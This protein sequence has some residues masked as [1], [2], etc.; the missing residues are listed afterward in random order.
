MKMTNTAEIKFT[1][2]SWKRFIASL[3]LLG[4]GILDLIIFQP[5]SGRHV[6]TGSIMT[7]QGPSYFVSAGL[8]PLLVGI[9]LILYVIFS[10]FKGK[11]FQKED[12]ITFEEKRYFLR[13]ETLFK[14]SDILL[15]RLTNNEIGIKY[16]WLFLFVPYLIFNYYY[17]ILNFNQ[18]F[19]T[20]LVNLTALITLISMIGTFLGMVILFMFPQWF[21][22]IFTKEG[23]YELWFEPFRNSNKVIK[24]FILS[25]NLK[26]GDQEK[27]TLKNYFQNSN[28]FNLCS[29]IFF[30]FYGIFSISAFMTTLAV[31]QTLISHFLLIMGIYLFSKEVRKTPINIE[32][33]KGNKTEFAEKSNYYQTYFYMNSNL[34][35]Q[36][37]YNLE[38]FDVFWII[39]LTVL[40]IAIPFKVI[41]NFLVINYLNFD[42]IISNLLLDLTFGVIVLL[43]LTIFIFRPTKMF[44]VK[45]DSFKKQFSLTKL[46]NNEL[47]KQ[48]DGTL[49]KR[50]NIFYHEFKTQYQGRSFFILI[51][52]VISILLILWQYFFYF[53]LF[54]I[55]N[56]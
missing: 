53:N 18:P 56:Y 54:N 15:I 47:Q 32:E 5:L 28:K 35:L 2:F 8:I 52:F 11:I 55:F 49:I 20:S 9:G 6:P 33:K 12:T 45:A 27:Y 37:K 51:C 43:L 13:N 10:Y 31:D 36:K 3:L 19:I 34:T 41:Q 26:Q 48:K 25:L 29:S 7:F 30:L 38:P 39:C 1:S 17:M 14:R 40:Y 50:W 42:I 44:S 46:E 16:L 21:L 24:G 23:R 22:E 4:V